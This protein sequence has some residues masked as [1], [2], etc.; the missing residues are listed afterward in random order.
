MP[1]KLSPDSYYYYYFL[2]NQHSRFFKS[3]KIFWATEDNHLL[4][5]FPEDKPTGNSSY[6]YGK[7][8]G[9]EEMQHFSII[10]AMKKK[11]PRVNDVC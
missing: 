6:V 4:P 3:S 11:L 2:Q 1:Q 8:Q 9:L 10:R 5:V 7:S